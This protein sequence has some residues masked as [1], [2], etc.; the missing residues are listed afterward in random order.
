[1]DDHIHISLFELIAE[2]QGMLEKKVQELIEPKNR[3]ELYYP[4]H[5]YNER[6]LIGLESDD[7]LDQMILL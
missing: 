7:L 5:L 6:E 4:I 1:M 2:I 3:F